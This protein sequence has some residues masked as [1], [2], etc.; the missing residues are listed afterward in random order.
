M[1]IFRAGKRVGPFDLRVG[2]PRDRSMDNIDRDPRLRKTAN[3]ENTIGRFRA[4]MAAASGY[5][6]PARFAVRIFPPTGLA[7][8][9]KQAQDVGYG[10]GQ[11]DPG[12]A[13]GAR[14]ASAPTGNCNTIGIAPN[15]S[16]IIFKHL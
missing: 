6:R 2:F 15:L 10:D 7:G 12:L 5:A 11:I 8:Q 14:Q 9:V 3:S 16:S 1:A 13:R 4:S